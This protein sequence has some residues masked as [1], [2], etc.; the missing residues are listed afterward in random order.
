MRATSVAPMPKHPLYTAIGWI[1]WK[2]GKRE[3]RKRIGAA[4][5]SRKFVRLTLASVAVSLVATFVA[6][7][8]FAPDQA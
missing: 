2:A 7:Q 8:A 6:R 5:P 1:V 3:A 4:A